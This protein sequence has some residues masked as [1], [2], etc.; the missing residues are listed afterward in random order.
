MIDDV[1]A[2]CKSCDEHKDKQAKVQANR[3]PSYCEDCGNKIEELDEEAYQTRLHEKTDW[4]VQ[5][6][7]SVPVKMQRDYSHELCGAAGIQELPFDTDEYFLDK[8][9]GSIPVTI[10]FYEDGTH[11]IV[12]VGEL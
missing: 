11:E 9:L 6:T 10:D 7:I 1:Y 12:D 4:P 5:A 2:Y 8:P 3:L